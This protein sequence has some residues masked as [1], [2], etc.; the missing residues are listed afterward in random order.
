MTRYGE[1]IDLSTSPAALQLDRLAP[2]PITSANPFPFSL[3]KKAYP[4]TNVLLRPFERPIDAFMPI[5][6]FNQS[7]NQFELCTISLAGSSETENQLFQI[8]PFYPLSFK[9]SND[10][11]IISN[12]PQ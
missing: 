4:T 3:N 12:C 11:S 9:A 2:I 1:C 8:S 6:T 7:I 5:S 10:S